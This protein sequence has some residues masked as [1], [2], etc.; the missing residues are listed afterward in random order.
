MLQLPNVATPLFRIPP[1]AV[2]ADVVSAA[3][4]RFAHE[5]SADAIAVSP[6]EARFES[7][8]E[9]RDSTVEAVAT[10]LN[11][12]C[13]RD[14]VADALKGGASHVVELTDEGSAA[15]SWLGAPALGRSFYLSLTTGTAMNVQ[16]AALIC[17]A[18]ADSGVLS[19]ERRSQVELC[20]HEAVANGVMHG[21]LGVSSTAKDQPGGYRLFS[22][23]LNER[24]REPARRR[25][26]IDVFTRWNDDE[27]TISVA[28][29]GDGFDVSNLRLQPDSQARSGRGF[30]FMRALSDGLSIGDGGRCTTLRFDL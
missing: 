30:L 29:E 17:D 21:N 1:Q 5:A 14:A 8:G 13:D 19:S 6:N 20:L 22:Q 7:G 28:D 23:L 9:R 24:L 26:R 15:G 12:N 25:R 4:A 2:P 11:S 16:P 27:L 10:L 18:L 3:Q